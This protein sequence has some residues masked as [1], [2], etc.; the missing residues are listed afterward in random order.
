MSVVNILM[1]LYSYRK[2]KAEERK[3]GIEMGDGNGGLKQQ[4][5]K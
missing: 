4:K 1:K 3:E 2:R 5:N